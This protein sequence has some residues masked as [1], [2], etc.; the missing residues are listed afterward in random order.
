MPLTRPSHSNR[1][2]LLQRLVHML[3]LFIAGWAMLMAAPT[4]ALARTTLDLDATSQ[5]VY[6]S[7]WGDY[8]IDT[9]GKMTA[10]QVN[11]DPAASWVPTQ[12]DFIYPVK[13]GQSLWIRFTVPPAPDSERWYAE[14][15]YAAINRASL[16]TLN[17]IGKWSEQRAGD[18]TP[19]SQWPVPHRHPLLPI[20]LSAEVP[21]KYLLQLE[22]RVPVSVP[23]RFID[24]RQLSNGEQK[25]SLVLGI[26]FGLT[27]LAALLSGLAGI[28]LRDPAYGY[29]AVSVVL[30]SF[31]HASLSGLGGLHLWPNS[32]WWSDVSAVV[33]PMLT[34]A[35]TVLFLS[36]AV[37]LFERSV[38]VHR[39]L[40]VAAIL[41]IFAA[42][43]VGFVA[44]E[45][46]TDLFALAML[47]M[48]T[49]GIAGVVW[50]W[51]RG[52]TFAPW[53]LLAY[54]PLVIAV[55]W[56]LGR[57]MGKVPIGFMT[58]HGLQVG[59][60]ISLPLTMIILMLRSQQR[61]EN[62]RRVQGLDRVDPATGLINRHVFEVRLTRMMARSERI[63]HQSAVML[64]DLVNSEQIQ[65]DFGRKAADDLPLR[66]AE[67]LLSTAREI[68]SA[69]RL[70]DK[71]FAMLVE[72]PV[73]FE[74]AGMLGPR[75]V[76]RCLM[77]FK[78]LHPDCTAQVRAVYALVPHNGT[79]AASLLARLEQRLTSI[80][81]D[82]KKAV[83]VLNESAPTPKRSRPISTST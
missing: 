27:G 69:A 67:R 56:A 9:T 35:T 10:Q 46:R 78:G 51:R 37:S 30:M 15:P 26:F 34:A 73:S 16:Y 21:T 44:A 17:S 29:Y 74:D 39:L 58:Q 53:L 32:P 36:S 55:F 45:R 54:M 62:T 43:A 76:A 66:V 20:A 38:G 75:I 13:N 3:G 11:D 50:A 79:D 71:R 7:D 60:A 81:P 2:V 47:C 48:Q 64:V 49:A 12:K 80:A 63:K 25:V 41:G 72:G 4:A 52:D 42:F 65:R 70:A 6:L 82:D 24:E 33:L 22:N 28:S 5:P 19:V 1:N 68:D 83:F 23:V 61:R 77:P 40:Q 57:S 14:V 59:A 8:R 18:L 31:A